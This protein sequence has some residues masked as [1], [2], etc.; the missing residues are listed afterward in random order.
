MAPQSVIRI[1]FYLWEIGER[2]TLKRT[3][4]G[5]VSVLEKK[6]TSCELGKMAAF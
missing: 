2:G 4:A 1:F 6:D 3:F 5:A